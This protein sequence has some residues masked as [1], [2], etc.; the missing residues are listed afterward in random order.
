[1]FYVLLIE[2]VT[3]KVSILDSG[4]RKSH[5]VSNRGNTAVFFAGLVLNS[6]PIDGFFGLSG[7]IVLLTDPL[8]ASKPR[9]MIFEDN[10]LHIVNDILIKPNYHFSNIS[11]L[12]LI[13]NLTYFY[14]L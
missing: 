1:M 12:N 14:P 7:P 10:F 9:V 13:G 3:H 6:V 2:N 11:N 5:S 4:I 8:S